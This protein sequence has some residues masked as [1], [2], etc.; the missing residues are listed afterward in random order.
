MAALAADASGPVACLHQI[1]FDLGNGAAPPEPNHTRRTREATGFQAYRLWS[2]ADAEALLARRFPQLLDV[3]RRLPHGINR[4]DMFR[5][6]IMYEFGGAYLDIDV[7]G[8]RNMAELMRDGVVV[9]GEEWP[10]SL[11]T[12]TVH[13]GILLCKTPGHPFW[14]MVISEI[15]RRLP[16]LTDPTDVQASVFKLTGPAMLRDVVAQYWW[17]C[18]KPT[19]PAAA[20]AAAAAAV[21]VLPFGVFCPIVSESL[22]ID[23][24]D[25]IGRDAPTRAL[26]CLRYPSYEHA[27][28]VSR[29]TFAFPT[30]SLETWQRAFR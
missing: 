7:L 16:R 19:T 17:C 10:F 15:A 26:R 24:Y 14:R 5:Y 21:V 30:A 22:Y 12:A 29:H 25:A 6:V 2:L 13:N 28:S 8:V 1:W 27:K 4:A 3:W 18:P 9:L 11:R 20:A 23:A